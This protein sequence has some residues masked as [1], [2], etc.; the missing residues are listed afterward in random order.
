MCSRT[1][2][3]KWITEFLKKYNNKINR[4][5]LEY[6][7]LNV[8]RTSLDLLPHYSRVVAIIKL[9]SKDF[10]KELVKSLIEE[11]HVLFKKKDQIK[12][13][14]KIKN[15]RFISELVKFKLIQFDIILGI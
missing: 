10:G 6:E 14:S 2:L 11:F 3:I 13:E 5:K 7:L 4:N 12:F 1:L 8:Q 9:N 15:I